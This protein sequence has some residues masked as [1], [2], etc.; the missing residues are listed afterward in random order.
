MK[1]A[2]YI[3]CYC[4]G[5]KIAQSSQNGLQGTNIYMSH[6]FVNEITTLI[7]KS[8]TGFISYHPRS[9]VVCNSCR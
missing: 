5:V 4:L 2:I 3:V 7:G 9:Q 8:L 1:K 6:D